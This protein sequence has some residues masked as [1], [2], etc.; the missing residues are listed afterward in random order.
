MKT[1]INRF[2]EISRRQFMQKTA[3]TALGVTLLPVGAGRLAAEGTGPGTPGF[4]KA[5]SVIY[6]YMS[7]GMSHI[8]TWDPKRGSTKGAKDPIKA[9]GDN[10]EALGGYM[11]NM[12]KV[13]DKIALI[14]SMTSKTG[15]HESGRYIMR[16]GYEPRGTIVHPSL[17]A[18]ASHFKGRIQG[19]TLPDSV[20]INSGNAGPG[21]GFFP[22][23]M[24]PIPISD[25]EA[26]LQNVNPTTSESMFT[27]RIS[28]MNE[29]DAS[30]RNKFESDEVS[31]EE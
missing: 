5:K 31:A 25:P 29:F 9:K 2:D 3:K 4:G 11:E 12:A 28:L 6:L 21:A 15:V 16:T 8:D 14:R 1:E 13:S 7:G 18:W 19:V 26:G 24:S 30:F 23:A 22:P 10:I 27:K 17:G 20:V